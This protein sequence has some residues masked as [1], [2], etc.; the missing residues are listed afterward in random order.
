MRYE[1]ILKNSNIKALLTALKLSKLILSRGY[2]PIFISI[3]PSNLLIDIDFLFNT[4]SIVLDLE[5]GSCL[6]EIDYYIMYSS[7]EHSNPTINNDL[8]RQSQS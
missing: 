6:A 4:V 8:D 7:L 1:K 3:Y 2:D 5:S